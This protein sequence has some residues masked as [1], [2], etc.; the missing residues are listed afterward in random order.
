MYCVLQITNVKDV[1]GSNSYRI[2]PPWF[3]LGGQKV[4]T[5]TRWSAAQAQFE[6]CRS[7]AGGENSDGG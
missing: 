5:P 1:D 4:Y 2:Y 6:T 3:T 7:R